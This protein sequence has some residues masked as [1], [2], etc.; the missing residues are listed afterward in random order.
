VFPAGSVALTSN[1]WLPGA[2]PE[3]ARGLV[4]LAKPPP[5]SW[6]WKVLPASVDVKLNVADVEL[7][8]FGGLAVIVVFAAVRS[9]VQVTLAGV[10]SLLPAGSV[11]LT[12]KVCAPSARPE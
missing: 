5:S 6:H 8:G 2:S 12:W 10:G 7:L 3:Y 9:T 11:A 1:V 4:Q